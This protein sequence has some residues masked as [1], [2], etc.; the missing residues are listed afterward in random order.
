MPVARVPPSTAAENAR[1]GPMKMHPHE[2]GP[3]G[4]AGSMQQKIRDKKII[5]QVNVN[6]GN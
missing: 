5:S 2:N 6:A 1:P 4:H 3:R